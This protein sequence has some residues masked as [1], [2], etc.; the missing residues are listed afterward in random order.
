MKKADMSDSQAAP[1]N[2]VKSLAGEELAELAGRIK[3][4][5]AELGFQQVL[6][7]DPE[8]VTAHYNLALVNMELGQPQA[9]QQH[10]ELHE[11]YRPD[12]QAVERA[13][14][15]HRRRNPAVNHAAEAVAV[16]DLQRADLEQQNIQAFS[17]SR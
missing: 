12:D 13:V 15:L 17:A 7:I 4:W 16:Y 14:S 3:S 6:T 10:R 1:E 2:G 8:N 5:G 9:A 11:Q